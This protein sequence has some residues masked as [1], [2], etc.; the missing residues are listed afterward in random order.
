MALSAKADNEHDPKERLQENPTNSRA[1]APN[2]IEISEREPCCSLVVYFRTENT[3]RSFLFLFG[4]RT[5]L[6]LKKSKFL[7][8]FN[9]FLFFVLR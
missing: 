9:L 5:S 3:D 6:V 8:L 2:S 1:I 4:T 7:F